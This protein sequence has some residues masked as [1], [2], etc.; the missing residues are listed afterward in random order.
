[1]SKITFIGAGST[2]FVKNVLGDVMTTPALQAS[3]SPC[4]ISIRSVSRIPSAC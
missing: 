3:S 1:M 4:S 2:V